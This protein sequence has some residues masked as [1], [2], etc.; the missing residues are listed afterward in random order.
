MDISQKVDIKALAENIFNHYNS[1]GEKPLSIILHNCGDLGEQV[2]S[3]LTDLLGSNN[4][5]ILVCGDIPEPPQLQNSYHVNI[6]EIAKYPLEF[7]PFYRS[8][9]VQELAKSFQ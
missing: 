5:E 7:I 6:G 2:A 4:I 1:L 3:C 9:S 8:R